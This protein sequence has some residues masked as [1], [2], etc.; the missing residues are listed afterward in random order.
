[1]GR[2]RDKRS[3]IRS[4]VHDNSV[5]GSTFFHVV[6]DGG[7]G[8]CLGNSLEVFLAASQAIFYKRFKMA[9]FFGKKIGARLDNR[10][11]SYRY[12]QSSCQSASIGQSLFRVIG[13]VK[14]HQ[15]AGKHRLL[16]IYK[17]ARTGQRLCDFAKAYWFIQ[18]PTSSCT[19]RA[20]ARSLAHEIPLRIGLV[21][22]S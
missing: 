3:I 11:K 4:N 19:R 18:F 1:M 2:H 16:V 22:T 20:P 13:S 14:R 9:D 8:E 21:K 15:Y 17:R 5:L 12:L 7:A 10:H 6:L